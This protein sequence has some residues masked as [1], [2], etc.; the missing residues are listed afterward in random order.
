VVGSVYIGEIQ[1]LWLLL[2]FVTAQEQGI[3]RSLG[4]ACNGGA[5]ASIFT[6]VTS[7]LPTLT[8]CV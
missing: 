3:G 2:G 5:A 7:R 6:S 1:V 4:G 8:E